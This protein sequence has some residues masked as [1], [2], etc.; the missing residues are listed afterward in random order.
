MGRIR[1]GEEAANAVV[2]HNSRVRKVLV[3]ALC[4]QDQEHTN[5]CVQQNARQDRPPH[6]GVA[7]QIHLTVI[8]DPKVDT[9]AHPRPLMW[10]R[11][12]RMLIHNVVVHLPH[13]LVQLEKLGQEARSLIVDRWGRLGILQWMLARLKVPQRVLHRRTAV[14]RHLLLVIRPVRE[15]HIVR[16]QVASKHRMTQTEDGAQRNRAILVSRTNAPGLLVD[17]NDPVVVKVTTESLTRKSVTRNL[18][19]IVARTH[20]WAVVV[21]RVQSDHGLLVQESHHIAVLHMRDIVVEPRILI[22]RCDRVSIFLF[23]V[24][25]LSWRENHDPLVVLV[26]EGVQRDLLLHTARLI[27]V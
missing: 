27:R 26:H 21:M 24:L 22:V 18:V 6:H 15:T 9:A 13:D 19:L 1:C 4:T 8:L 17:F 23:L 12:V 2:L 20:G 10:A 16:I 7:N 11:A 14:A 5:A 3:S 25:I